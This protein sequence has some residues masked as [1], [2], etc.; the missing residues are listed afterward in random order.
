MLPQGL[1]KW[2]FII[3]L[4]APYFVQT[5]IADGVVITSVVVKTVVTVNLV[6][7][8]FPLDTPIMKWARGGPVAS[9]II[10]SSHAYVPNLSYSLG[11]ISRSKALP[12]PCQGGLLLEL[13]LS[14]YTSTALL[15]APE[16]FPLRE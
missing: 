9:T 2:Y 12:L 15:F 14:G 10:S 7:E 11:P 1:D 16:F 6:T 4:W 3:I 8:N 5:F 13:S